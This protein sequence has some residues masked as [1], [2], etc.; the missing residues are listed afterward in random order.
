VLVAPL[1]PGIND[2]PEQVDEIVEI[3]KQAGATFVN[4]IALHLRPGVREV[5]MS[6]LSAARPDL[7]PR[8]EEIYARGAYAE[9]GE[10][11]R[12]G[13]LVRGA[14]RGSRG[15]RTSHERETAAAER[16]G[17]KPGGRAAPR[18]DSLF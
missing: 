15:R 8:Y 1:M 6:W 16:G 14:P 18:Q 3:A 17:A 13:K 4:G 7:V 9:P 12:I 5:F 2:E 10:R 11:A